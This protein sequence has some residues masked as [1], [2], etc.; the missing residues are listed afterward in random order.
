[1]IHLNVVHALVNV[2]AL[3]PLMERF[4]SEYGTL[5]TLA[6]FFGRKNGPYLYTVTHYRANK[7]SFNNHS[8]DIISCDRTCHFEGEYYNHGREVCSVA[9]AQVI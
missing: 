8:G 7:S 9:E 1:M 2:V 5:S 6:L 3:T 4:E